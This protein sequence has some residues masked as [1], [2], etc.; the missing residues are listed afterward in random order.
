MIVSSKTPPATWRGLSRNGRGFTLIEL[1][2]AIAMVAVI[3]GFSIGY[4]VNL[5][6][7]SQLTATQKFLVDEAKLSMEYM[8]RELRMA[9][10][11]ATAIVVNPGGTPGVQFDKL[12]AYPKDPTTTAIKYAWNSVSK[13]LQRTTAGGTITTTLSSNVSAFSVAR[14]ADLFTIAMT[15]TGPDGE[16]FTL[17]SAVIPRSL[18]G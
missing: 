17:T 14:S 4:V 10:E 1:I 12:N 18:T 7:M 11:S 6:Q 2:L 5:T 16:T 15:L 3:G 8:T 13:T 9:S